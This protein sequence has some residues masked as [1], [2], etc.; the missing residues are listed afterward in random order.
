MFLTKIQKLG[1]F[2]LI[3][4][5][6]FTVCW[7]L[8]LPFRFFTYLKKLSLS[9]ILIFLLNL[10]DLYGQEEEDIENLRVKMIVN[11]LIPQYDESREK[12]IINFFDAFGIYPYKENYFLFYTYDTGD[13][14]ERKRE[15]A[16]FQLSFMKP[17]LYNLFGLNEI[18]SF[19]YTQ[20]S[21]WQV[22][23]H[24]APFRETNYEPEVMVLFPI[25]NSF[26]NGFKISLNHQSNGQPE[27]KSRSWN[28]VIFET[29]FSFGDVR[30]NIQIW[31]RIPENEENDDNPDILHYLGNG[32]IELYIPYGANLFKFTVRN[33]LKGSNNRGSFQFDWSFPIGYFKN[34][35][36]Y[37]QYFSGYGES[38]IDYNRPIDKFGIGIMLTR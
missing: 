28:R 36:I 35:Y 20:R 18:Y 5:N 9:V 26:L 33:N 27:G 2:Q 37:F 38:L 11:T 24:S 7:F 16:K 13:T 21:F 6:I 19:A 25:N 32:Q 3:K 15:E 17:M 29:I 23:S 8:R 14:P 10:S 4:D 34:T 12:K 31:Y 30:L 22:Y 1:G